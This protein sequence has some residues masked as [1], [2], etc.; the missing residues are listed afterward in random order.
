MRGLA[1]HLTELLVRSRLATE[2]SLQDSELSRIR[3]RDCD[4]GSVDAAS[5]RAHLR[6]RSI[7]RIWSNPL[8]IRISQQSRQYQQAAS[9]KAEISK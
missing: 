2:T 7:I 8:H 5:D 4:T 3:S 6:E 9:T 1:C